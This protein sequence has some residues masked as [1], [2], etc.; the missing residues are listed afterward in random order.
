MQKFGIFYMKARVVKTGIP[1]FK[2]IENN[3]LGNPK[4]PDRE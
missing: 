3:Y 1:N 4:E 2:M